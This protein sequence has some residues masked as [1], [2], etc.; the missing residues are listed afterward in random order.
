MRRQAIE[1]VREW[2]DG[3]NDLPASYADSRDFQMDVRAIC[4]AAEAEQSARL[5]IRHFLTAVDN[6]FLGR[7]PDDFNQSAFVTAL[8]VAAEQK[9]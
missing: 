6:E 5:A 8:R 1:L 9:E 4:A 3:G 7:M 2:N